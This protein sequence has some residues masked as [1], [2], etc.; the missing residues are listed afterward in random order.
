MVWHDFVV[1]RLFVAWTRQRQI[2]PL[3]LQ[4]HHIKCCKHVISLS[5]KISN[6]DLTL[7]HSLYQIAG[8]DMQ[9]EQQRAKCDCKPLV[10][11]YSQIRKRADKSTIGL[12]SPLICKY[13]RAR[14][15]TGNSAL[16]VASVDA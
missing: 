9:S 7:T 6:Q 13:S 14:T 10:A 15:M 12:P 1:Y 16:E 8:D 2:A 5:L 3:D 4:L 11:K